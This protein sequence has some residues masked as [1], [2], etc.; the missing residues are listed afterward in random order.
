MEEGRSKVKPDRMAKVS[1]SILDENDASSIA[2][3]LN[4]KKIWD[5]IR[6]YVPH[7]YS[8]KDAHE[9]IER[10]SKEDPIMTFAIRWNDQLAGVIG[11]KP[12][13]DVHRK[14]V[15]IGYWVGEPYWGKGIAT[16]AIKQMVSYGFAKL[17]INRIFAGI[18]SHNAPSMKA[19]ENCGFQKEG[20]FRKAVIK[21]GVYLDE[22][23][24]AILK[25]DQLP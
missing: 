25:E 16:Q 3:L 18:Y 20:V 13:I 23:K 5:N 15:E 2:I 6:D 8:K 17:D 12:Q 11:F 14:S 9:F 21:N 7:P 24:Y 1:L 4:N 19:L 10:A 22:V